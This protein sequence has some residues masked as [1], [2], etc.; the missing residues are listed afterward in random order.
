MNRDNNEEPQ[1]FWKQL[2]TGIIDDQKTALRFGLGGGLVGAIAGTALGVF[3]FSSFGLTGVGVCLL[4]GAVIGFI[5]AWFLY[6]SF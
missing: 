2:V 5:G 3:L 6:L 1:S 4:G